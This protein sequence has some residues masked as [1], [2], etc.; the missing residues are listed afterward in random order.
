MDAV[1]LRFPGRD[2]AD[3]PLAMGVH[4]LARAGDDEVEIIE[5]ADADIRLCVDRRGVW[6]AVD[7]GAGGVHVNGRSIRRLAMLRVGDT[8]Y[9]EG[10][11]M[12]LVGEQPPQVPPPGLQGYGIEAPDPRVVLRGV[13][14]RYHGRSFTLERPRLVGRNTTA[15][16][17]IDDPAFADRHARLELVGDQVVLRD[18]GS[19]D[20]SVVNGVTM[21]DAVLLAGDQVVFDAH[22]RFVVE[23]PRRSLPAMPDVATGGAATLPDDVDDDRDGGPA[24]RLPWLLLA[25]LLLAML[26]SALLLFGPG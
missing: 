12:R 8:I 22:H 21:R 15:D 13:G 7:G 18:L 5:G 17:R 26:L 23:A 10:I 20:G 11:E 9:V 25:A 14:G 4:A 6:L 19:A 2:T 24:W 16:I 1:K 3:R